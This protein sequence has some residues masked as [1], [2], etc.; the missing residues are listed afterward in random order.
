MLLCTFHL[1]EG[2]AISRN[3]LSY[4]EYQDGSAANAAREVKLAWRSQSHKFPPLHFRKL[5]RSKSLVF[6][7]R[8]MDGDFSTAIV[9]PKGCQLVSWVHYSA[10]VS[11]S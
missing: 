8:L 10:L 11:R 7:H 6:R 5:L 3:L 9:L 1:S 4:F 2:F